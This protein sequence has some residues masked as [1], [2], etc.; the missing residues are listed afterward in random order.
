VATITCRAV[1]VRSAVLSDGRRRRTG[2]AD[3]WPT[4]IAVETAVATVFIV[5]AAAA[6]TGS[7]WLMVAGLAGHGLKDLWEHHTG[8]VSNTWWWPPFC[9]AVDFVAAT[10]MAVAI[11]ADFRFRW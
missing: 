2:R 9:A 3:G 6:V 1:Y 4:I 8:F 11:P 5:L 10:V 7:A